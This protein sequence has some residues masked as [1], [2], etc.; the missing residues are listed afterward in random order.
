MTYQM[1]GCCHKSC[2]SVGY[3]SLLSVEAW[4]KI[5]GFL[6][7][8][9]E[10]AVILSWF[11]SGTSSASPQIP[12]GGEDG[13]GQEINFTFPSVLNVVFWVFPFLLTISK[14]TGRS[15]FHRKEVG[16]GA[17]SR[18][19]DPTNIFIS[20]VKYKAHEGQDLI[21][22]LTCVCRVSP[23]TWHTA[24]AQYICE[25]NKWMN[26]HYMSDTFM[27]KMLDVVFHMRKLRYFCLAVQCP[28]CF[29]PQ[30]MW[31]FIKPPCLTSAVSSPKFSFSATA[32]TT[33]TAML[34]IPSPHS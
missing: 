21:Y 16:D 29:H 14:S 2:L 27:Y 30:T 7:K 31:S 10:E 11:Y 32:W 15:P 19:P 18:D 25:M 13:H 20:L 8:V 17:G 5:Y 33:G 34:K 26:E 22:L 4:K 28:H 9:W 6:G 24:N 3:I 12:Y 1:F 23:G